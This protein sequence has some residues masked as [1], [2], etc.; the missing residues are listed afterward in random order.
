MSTI[1]SLIKGFLAVGHLHSPKQRKLQNMYYA[2]EWETNLK[3]HFNAWWAT[4][5]LKFGNDA[6]RHLL[7]ERNLFVERA[8]KAEPEEYQD[9]LRTQIDDE[10]KVA[11]TRWKKMTGSVK[12]VNNLGGDE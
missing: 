9:N 2:M 6:G 10:H 4:H 7:R 11:M 1:A 5:Q 8:L 3:P 12:T